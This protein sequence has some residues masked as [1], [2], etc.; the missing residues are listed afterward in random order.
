M[1]GPD[2]LDLEAPPAPPKKKRGRPPKVKVEAWAAST[3]PRTLPELLD[4][5]AGML[6]ATR[7]RELEPDEA[8][9]IGALIKAHRELLELEHDQA[10]PVELQ[11]VEL[12]PKDPI[13]G[14]LLARVQRILESKV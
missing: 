11:P 7:R 6:D 5:S 1:V 12:Q 4:F 8:R 9:A 2:E 14:E 3:P 10:A 13:P